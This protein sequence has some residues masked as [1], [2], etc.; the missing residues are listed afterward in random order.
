MK[1]FI[2]KSARS[3]IF[4]SIFLLGLVAA[5]AVY[6]IPTMSVAGGN[7]VEISFL[8]F[9]ATSALGITAYIELNRSYKLNTIE[10]LTFISNR[11][12]SSEIITARQLIHDIFVFNYRHN[13]MTKNDYSAAVEKSSDDILKMSRTINQEGRNFIYLLNLLDHFESISYFYFINQITIDEVRNIYGNNMI[14]YYENLYSY[15]K[16]RQSRNSSDFEN[17]SK[18]YKELKYNKLFTCKFKKNASL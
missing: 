16:Q 5:I 7:D 3:K 1:T 10:L 14:F 9:I 15:I 13:P 18:L 17:Y 8:I 4:Y 11:W 6:I 12:S 2:K